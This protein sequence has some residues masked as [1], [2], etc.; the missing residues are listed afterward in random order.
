MPLAMATALNGKGGVGVSEDNEGEGYLFGG[1]WLEDAGG[2]YVSLG[3]IPVLCSHALVGGRPG[4]KSL[5]R[6][7]G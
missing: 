3:P 7:D 6:L 2:I 5:L 1:A 4:D